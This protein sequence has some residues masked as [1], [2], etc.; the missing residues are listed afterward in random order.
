MAGESIS[1]RVTAAFGDDASPDFAQKYLEWVLTNSREI[2]ASLRRTGTLLVSL[3]AL[4]LL[5]IGAKHAQVTLGPLKLS[6]TSSVLA[7]LP[8]MASY[9]L[10]DMLT[11]LSMSNRYGDLRICV[12]RHLHAKA[13]AQGLGSALSP[14][15]PSLWGHAPMLDL[16][17]APRNTRIKNVLE[18]M[19]TAV[20]LAIVVGAVLFM[21]YAYVRLFELHG[22][23]EP[24]L[25]ASLCFAAFNLLRAVLLV[26]EEL[27]EQGG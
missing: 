12:F 8:A 24:L 9:L 1:H 7:L 27:R 23:S 6:E 19:A 13:A 5:L 3:V 21:L 11:L 16:T 14:P 15:V 20:G 22:V 4:F 10:V 18:N 25:W 26:Y 17:N 2:Q